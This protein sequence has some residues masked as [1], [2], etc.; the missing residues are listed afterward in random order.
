MDWRLRRYGSLP[1][2]SDLCVTLAH[3]GEAE[4]LA[5]LADRQTSGRGSHGRA[6]D[7]RAGNLYL[8]MLLRPPVPAGEAGRWSLLAAVAVAEAMAPYAP[9]LTLKWPN[10]VLR[11]DAKLA[12]IL[13]DSAAGA[14]GKLDWL[15]I[16]IGVNL[17]FAPEIEGRRIA[18]IGDRAPTP[19]AAAASLLDR[20]AYWHATYLRGGFAPIRAA[21]LA[22]AH[23]PGTPLRLRQSARQIDGAFAGLAEDGSLLIETGGRVRAY[24]AGELV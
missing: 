12:G 11:D 23:P 19:D 9:D 8:S 21:W 13:V 14:D 6:W 17:A 22:R 16:G 3:A 5:V 20:I 7:S 10:D 1:S 18:C 15:V 24:V 2:T 4:G